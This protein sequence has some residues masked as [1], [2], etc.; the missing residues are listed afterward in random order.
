MLR[1]SGDTSTS[2]GIDRNHELDFK[3]D[4]H[5]RNRRS[6]LLLPAPEGNLVTYRIVSIV[7]WMDQS[8]G[9]DPSASWSFGCCVVELSRREPV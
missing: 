5:S 9:V 7:P 4:K 1:I 6:G 2:L 3:G 8:S